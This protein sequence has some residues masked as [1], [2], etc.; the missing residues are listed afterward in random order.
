MSPS[1]A[2]RKMGL[3][4]FGLLLVALE[5]ND[6]GTDGWKNSKGKSR[7]VRF[8]MAPPR[9]ATQRFFP[10]RKSTAC[11]ELLVIFGCIFHV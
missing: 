3:R 8:R 4:G 7:R 5:R 11:N 1:S 2:I 10:P 9:P 6:G